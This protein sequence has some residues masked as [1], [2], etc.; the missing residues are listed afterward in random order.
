MVP[1]NV[2]S[3][4]GESFSSLY[5]RVLDRALAPSLR[6]RFAARA[7]SGSLD[8]ALIAG[9]D[10]AD[11]P[12]LAARAAMLTS[13]LSRTSIAEGLER[14]LAAAQGPAS[15]RRMR[16]LRAPVLA[17]AGELRELAALLRGSSPLYARGIALLGQLLSDGT[18]P[19]YFGEGDVLARRLQEARE[20][21]R[22]L[23]APCP[24]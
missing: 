4:A 15:Q 12:Q 19:A 23:E 2:E 14:L 13:R 3:A 7:R 24:V 8:R 22:G 21:M 6:A 20:A 18:G 9:A 11:A 17:S 16:P 10:P 5:D 1:Q